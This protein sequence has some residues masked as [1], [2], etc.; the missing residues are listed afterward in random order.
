M[1]NPLTHKSSRLRNVSLAV[2]VVIPVAAGIALVVAGALQPRPT[3]EQVS[4]LARS[5][6][7]DEALA[8]GNLYLRLFPSDARVLLVMAEIELSRP[9]PEPR[10]ALELLERVEQER[11]SLAG[12]VL[13][14]RG[15]AHYLL[16]RFDQSEACWMGAL[17]NDPSVPE[18]GRRLLDLLGL[19]GRF[20][21]A[22]DVA[23]RQFENEPDLRERLKL[24]LRLARFDVDPPDPWLVVT[25]FE[26]A[27]L[28]NSANLSTTLACGLALVAVSRSHE[29]LPM[30]RRAVD[31]NPDSPRAWDA[32]LTGLETAAGRDKVAGEM[33]RM[34]QALAAEL[35]FAKHRGWLQQEQGHWHEAARA[36][37][38]A[39]SFEPDN[40]VG[41]RLCHTL[42]LA[43]KGALADRFDRLVLDYRGA[44]K[45][46]RALLDQVN[47]ALKDG[48]P[49]DMTIYALM[50]G[51]RERMGRTREA[52]A[53][54][55]L[56]VLSFPG[57]SSFFDFESAR[58][59]S[60]ILEAHEPSSTRPVSL[61]LALLP[62]SNPG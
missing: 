61:N 41:Y 30:L 23:L 36:Y 24:L 25:T 39:W 52:E 2:A 50:A 9:E 7:F 51:L 45:Q 27:V 15:T 21:E 17:K 26:P 37:E 56:A 10:R 53:W 57:H 35:R 40:A 58:L 34:P 4:D 60:T 18:A 6:R 59:A 46:T 54:R 28:A 47:A 43:G 1:K 62:E 12:W 29:G 33:A 16:G 32:L 44:F 13:V 14:D 11:S 22:R 3:L 48:S 20:D 31:R 38:Q 5:K 19:Q 49:I 8:Q 42:R 55:K